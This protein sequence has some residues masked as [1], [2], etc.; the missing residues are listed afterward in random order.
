ELMPGLA[1]EVLWLPE[2]PEWIVPM[3]SLV[4]LQQLAYH[5]SVALGH[6]PDKPRNLAK[7]VTVE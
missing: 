2:A 7:S 1:D 4:P 3:L 6:N 5:T